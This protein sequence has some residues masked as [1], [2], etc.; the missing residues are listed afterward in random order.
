MSKNR[1]GIE[2]Q[3]QFPTIKEL[4]TQLA[5]KWASIKNNFEGKINVGIDG[6]S[7]KQLKTQINTA[8]SKEVFDI[9]L[10]VQDAIKGIEKIQTELNNLDKDLKKT[11]ELKLD[12]S[13]KDMDK[14]L[15][16]ILANSKQA[17]E[18]ITKE[19]VKSSKERREAFERE[20][21]AM[22]DSASVYAKA[23]EKINNLKQA[24]ESRKFTLTRDLGKGF[25]EQTT[26]K[27]DGTKDKV[28]TNN[29]EKARKQAEAD[30]IKQVKE[31]EEYLKRIHKINMDLV[32]A[33]GKHR[34][35]LEQQKKE[36]NRITDE[37][38]EQYKAK[39][40]LNALDDKAVQGL[41]EQHKQAMKLKLEKKEQKELEGEIEKAI[42]SVVQLER[43]KQSLEKKALDATEEE[44]MS[45]RKQYD[46]H[47]DIQDSLMK[48]HN[49]Q[50]KMTKEQRE[51]FE[52][53]KQIGYLER[54]TITA[55]RQQREEAQ[56]LSQEEKERQRII[57]EAHA[58]I[59][60]DLKAVHKL[61]LQVFEVKQKQANSGRDI[62]RE[63]KN[64]L[65]I[66]E[67]ELRIAEDILDKT[68]ESH[69]S[70]GNITTELKKQIDIEDSILQRERNR[71]S[72]MADIHGNQDKVTVAMKEH[73]D[74]AR[75][76]AQLQR[77]VIFAGMR[78]EQVI[79]SQIR[80]LQRKQD[81]IRQN[82]RSQDL[83]TDAVQ[84]EIRQIER[85]QREQLQLNRLR[86]DAREKDGAF[87]D[88]GGLVD[89]FAFAS[90]V[91]QGAM[92]IFDP[93]ARYDEALI[94][95]TKVAETTDDQ[96]KNFEA[97]VYDV[98]SS[99]G[100]TADE[101][102]LAVEKW[103]TAGKTF[104]Q[105][106]DLANIAMTGAFVGSISPDEM[107]KFMSVP[108]EAFRREGL[109]AN[110]IINIM[111]ETANNHAI[112][113]NDL[114]KAYVRS[115]N[116]AKSSGA[117]FEEL[118]A[119]ITGAQE[120]T[121]KGGERIG[122]GIKTIGINISSIQSQWKKIDQVNFEYLDSLGMEL[123]NKDGSAKTM[124]E[125]IGELARVQGQLKPE[126]YNN[127]VKALAGKEHSETLMGIVD[128]WDTVQQTIREATLE[129]GRGETGSAY[130]EHAKQ[131]DSVKFKTAELK[132][133]WDE[134]MTTMG[135]GQD[136][137]AK[138]LGVLVE[139]L[140]K[141]NELAENKELMR[142]AEL[143]FA[144]LAFHA[145]HNLARRFFDTIGTGMGT[146]LQNAREASALTQGMFRRRGKTDLFD[147]DTGSKGSK[148]QSSA[149]IMPTPIYG[150]RGKVTNKKEI[151]EAQ[152]QKIQ[153][154]KEYEKVRHKNDIA[155]MG[156]VKKTGQLMGKMF[157]FIPLFGDLLLL[158]EFTGV[159]VFETIGKIFENLTTSAKEF[160]E[161]IE[162][163]T[164][165]TL[166]TNSITNG[167]AITNMKKITESATELN[168]L[169]GEKGY[170]NPD[171]FVE[172]REQF[173]MLAEEMGAV[174]ANGVEIRV[175]MNDTT[176]ITKKLQEL[177]EFQLLLQ[178][179]DL[180][181]L[182]EEVENN[183]GSFKS[184]REDIA[185]KED[186][187]ERMK[188]DNEE[189]MELI[190]VH[191]KR[192]KNNPLSVKDGRA[193][194]VYG[195]QWEAN[196]IRMKEL[197]E[198]IEEQQ[199][200]LD[201][202]MQSTD[203]YARGIVDYVAKGGNLENMNLDKEAMSIVLQ[204]VKDGYNDIRDKVIELEKVKEAVNVK[205]GENIKLTEEEWNTIAQT[206]DSLSKYS[207]ETLTSKDE[208]L[209]KIQ[210]EIQSELDRQKTY[211]D[212]QKATMD[213]LATIT[214]SIVTMAE[215]KTGKVQ[216]VVSET[217]E[218]YSSLKEDMEKPVEGNITLWV[219]VKEG[220]NKLGDIAKKAW[221]FMKG[222]ASVSA[223]TGEEPS[224]EATASSSASGG[225]SSASVSSTGGSLLKEPTQ[226][227]SID[228]ATSTKSTKE[229]K[230]QAPPARVNSDIWR[231][232]GTEM[233]IEEIT[234]SINRLTS[235]IQ[236]AT[237]NENELIKLYKQQNSTLRKEESWQ[238]KLSGQKKSEMSEV[239]KKLRGYG[240]RTSG[241]DITNLG[242]AK[243]LRGDRA[244]KAE[245]LL[246]TWKSLGADL[247]SISER[248]AT[249]NETI[250]DNTEAMKQ[251]QIS[252]ELKAFEKTIKR[253]EALSTKVSNSDSLVGQRLS[254]I[255]PENLELSLVENEKAMNASKS[256]MSQ[257]INEFN[258]LSKATINYEENGKELESHL[259]NLGSQILA[260]ADAVLQYK[261]ALNDLEI[262]R[263]TS[264]LSEFSSAMSDM[265]SNISNNIEN[266]KE[267]LLNGQD[268][269]DLQ[270]S[271]AV[272]LRLNRDNQYEKIAQERI[273]LEKEVQDALAGF[274]KKNV[275]R[276][277]GVA[278]ATLD[279]NAKMYNQILKMEKDHT[280][281]R[282]ASYNKIVTEFKDLA[283]IGLKDEDYKFVKNLDNI[284]DSISKKQESI[285]NKYQKDMDKATSQAVKDSL[286][287]QYIIDSL[288]LQE[289]A[290]KANI[291][292]NKKAIQ[293]LNKQLK[294]TSLTDSQV[295]AIKQ[296]ISDYE[297]EIID[298]Q[299]NIKDSIAER[300][301]FEFSLLEEAISEYEKYTSELEYAQEILN[302]VGGDNSEA[303]GAI[304]NEM[305]SIEKSR[306]AQLSQTINSLEKQLS[307]YEEGSYEWNLINSEVEG[308][309]DLL[310]E[311][312]RELIDMN[313][314]IMSNS[315]EGTMNSLEKAMFGGR[316]IEELDRQRELWLEGLEKEIALEDTYK[317]IADLETKMYDGRMEYLAKQEKLS[318]Y[319][320]DYLNKQLDIL[321]LQNK[322]D[323]LNNERTVQTLRQQAD[324]T[325]DWAYE[326]DSTQITQ[327]QEELNQKQLEL[328]QME[329]EARKNYL[330][331]L[332]DILA[333]AEEGNFDNIAEF[334]GAIDDLGKAFESIVGDFPQI[335]ESYLEELVKAYS[336]YIAENGDIL[337]NIGSGSNYVNNPVFE[338]FSSEIVR[339][340]DD[341]SKDIGEAFA[342]ALISK[343]PSFAVPHSEKR[344]EDKSVSINLDK[345]EFP[346]VTSPD[347]IKD[348]ILSLPKIALQKS[349]EK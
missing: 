331:Q 233:T 20:K 191:S 5:Q 189:L 33:T 75:Q 120:A 7:L 23:Q 31:I 64:Q 212:S 118:T 287:N 301:E 246:N 312:N 176:D 227:A 95:I 161:E 342:D 268:I 305:M 90:R 259:Q 217:G 349:K 339:A 150:K 77:D 125:V 59:L 12:F 213:S 321:E 315:F 26:L 101:Y 73:E 14:T 308:Y 159:P 80:E 303:I 260:Q 204:E 32:D 162:E 184:T 198:G 338:G 139:G 144:G 334:R 319:E 225:V 250:K 92:A 103:V 294:D 197:E 253:I 88:T 55:K 290:F 83:L 49:L 45:L 271:K 284:F 36:E 27:W 38:L 295:E 316:T 52:N 218:Q 99:L 291:E 327:T 154:E 138:V 272:E 115:A 169:K 309:R 39:N 240:F 205:S 121:R 174:D 18:K 304:L 180:N 289:S 145:G 247:T 43:K 123:L 76:I 256:N 245:E 19:A 211:E 112:E 185:T 29:A 98:G 243:S 51:E 333:D 100:V 25:S 328:Q 261:Q 178:Q 2:V 288:K 67:R 129:M 173:N 163:A 85:A 57:K 54:E 137:V 274:A 326:A 157:G 168:K 148:Q 345:I 79:E 108:F 298:S 323:N 270:S 201:S 81:V 131:S 133:A 146:F 314:N 141:I 11:R 105:S 302:A 4:Q 10:N 21:K 34:D 231:Y 134:L 277:K 269:K 119:M 91:E 293:E 155:Q 82:L 343:I 223:P 181:K 170:L 3:V 292:A 30:R 177:K 266:V 183:V 341:I 44:L 117:T 336:D 296:A 222:D 164:T 106:Q 258:K 143:V 1:I 114:G 152:K 322:L 156:R 232:W 6:N 234:Q 165:K 74:L 16:D 41:V 175:S 107:V 13:V 56:R 325:W 153:A 224:N 229:T 193:V 226:V 182:G 84:E 9:Q 147:G 65:D 166:A 135:G 128:Q 48:K 264:D 257:L 242:H 299:N 214:G 207:Y 60:R 126:E 8:L 252:K 329:E 194:A 136:G 35:A 72:T 190:M 89:P 318:R 297:K 68:F 96:L 61:E 140:E 220:L 208:H 313:K 124:T 279:V 263:V 188:K 113:M 262:S 267:G 249:I 300:F 172:Y 206:Y 86:Q 17:N 317:R 255:D 196:N 160:R 149:I 202:I 254:L 93:I 210:E 46:Y 237:D 47:S 340:F 283:N 281:G 142:M 344:V 130:L 241:N 50:E 335:K 238:R 102:M 70:Q 276:V 78:E 235:A 275:D 171:E 330:G 286:T 239:L 346:N 251:A 122:T 307:L 87:N 111:N 42:S 216:E 348:A 179:N 40:N 116:T 278:N 94:G 192:F 97:T 22:L 200:S 104:E 282:K 109:E 221:N 28:V 236:N 265:N 158:A 332:E 244:T 69:R 280:A 186:Q 15:S 324:G 199:E 230:P 58:E 132:N 53:V 66:L 209:G 273:N 337:E 195:A 347:G 248:I 62:T 310:K 311:S 285:T 167:D 63:E 203:R 127:A 215:D 320:M 219:T 71:I 24:N 110:D 37:L 228:N 151:K 306:N 187:I